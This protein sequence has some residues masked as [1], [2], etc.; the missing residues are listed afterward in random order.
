MRF[1]AVDHYRWVYKTVI[2]DESK[3]GSVL[4]ERD[5]QIG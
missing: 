4:T 5:L 2:Q 3:I 1:W